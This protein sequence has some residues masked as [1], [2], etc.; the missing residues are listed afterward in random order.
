L[1]KRYS[2]TV[3]TKQ[4]GI[5]STQRQYYLEFYAKSL[6]IKEKV[7]GKEHPDTKLTLE[8]IAGTYKASGKH[9]PFDAWLKKKLAE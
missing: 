9:E 8:N 2:R 6:A 4:S 1:F 7:L 5:F 3:Q